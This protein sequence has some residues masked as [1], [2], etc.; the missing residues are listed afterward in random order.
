MIDVHVLTQEGCD[1]AWLDQCLESLSREPCT[2]H[3]VDNTGK[4]VGEG[5]AHGYSLGTNPYVAHVDCDDYVLPGVME[6]AIKGLE[7]FP[8]ITTMERVEYRGREFFNAPRAGHNM[9]AARRSL[10]EPVLGHLKTIPWVSDV[11]LRRV[12]EPHHVEFIG[13]V[14]RLHDKQAHRNVT[15]EMIR[16]EYARWPK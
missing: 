7:K 6:A 9:F 5:R 11:M 14:W 10:V 3:V 15:A 13:Y 4:S 1:P 2:V 8:C 16:H 12:Y